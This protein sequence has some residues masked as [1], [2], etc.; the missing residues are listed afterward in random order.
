MLVHH[1]NIPV[2][3]LCMVLLPNH[4]LI[5]TPERILSWHYTGAPNL[6]GVFFMCALTGSIGTSNCLW[7]SFVHTDIQLSSTQLEVKLVLM[8]HFALRHASLS[9][10]AT[11]QP[12]FDMTS[13]TDL[14]IE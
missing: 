7:Q 12:E 5:L 13:E 11:R 2:E 3:S 8:S 10:I 4:L 1:H 14:G 6:K 9:F